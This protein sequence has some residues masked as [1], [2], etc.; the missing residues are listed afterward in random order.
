MGSDFFQ[1]EIVGALQRS[2]HRRIDGFQR[3]VSAAVGCPPSPNAEIAA[4][5]DV[6]IGCELLALQGRLQIE[7][8]AGRPTF[9]LSAGAAQRVTVPPAVAPVVAGAVAVSVLGGCST[10][11]LPPAPPSTAPSITALRAMTPIR[12]EQVRDA[13]HSEP[14]FA[15]CEACAQPTPKTR[16][17]VAATAGGENLR[18]MPPEI[19]AAAQQLAAADPPKRA[20]VT[21]SPSYIERRYVIYFAFGSSSVDGRAQVE[22]AR[23]VSQ[24]AGA[25]SVLITGSTDAVGTT[26]VNQRLAQQRAAQVAQALRQAGWPADRLRQEAYVN[27]PAAKVDGTVALGSPARTLAAAARHVEIVALVPSAGS[28]AVSAAATAGLRAP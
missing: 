7:R 26:A 2:R 22:L 6:A 10:V 19:I 13:A 27:R 20:S 17:R 23:V 5:Q 28:A 12:V 8:A 18:F 1:E 4:A 15:V 24:L 21:P 14:Y 3:L 9:R 16:L 25:K 11:M